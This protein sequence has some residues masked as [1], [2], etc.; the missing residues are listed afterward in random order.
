MRYFQPL[1]HVAAA[2]MDK[3]ACRSSGPEDVAQDVILEFCRLLAGPEADRK[4]PRLAT[5]QQL[6]SVLVCLTV[7]EA[8]DKVAKFRQRA[9]IVGG[10][11]AFGSAGPDG[12]KGNEPAPEFAAAVNELFE[13]LQDPK[14]P[15][16]GERLQ[17][18]ARMVMEGY[19]HA[20][21][22]GTLGCSERN[23]GRKLDLIRKI[24]RT[25]REEALP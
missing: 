23:V 7:R 10:G 16:Q 1:V 15:E 17:L 6:W 19:T 22:A 9:E 21:I 20:E 13:Q 12:A 5:R 4:F 8:F 25:H 14:H 2:R 24:W 18:V 3:A 11:S